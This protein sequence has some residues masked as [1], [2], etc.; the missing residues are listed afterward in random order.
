MW[1][2][3]G[4]CCVVCGVAWSAQLAGAF[5]TYECKMIFL[6]FSFTK[7]GMPAFSHL[8]LTVNRDTLLLTAKNQRTLSG[9]LETCASKKDHATNHAASS[10][11]FLVF[12]GLSKSH[13]K[14][15]R[16]PDGE[17]SK[18]DHMRPVFIFVYSNGQKRPASSFSSSFLHFVF[19]DY[20][21]RLPCMHARMR[22]VPSCSSSSLLGVIPG[23]LCFALATT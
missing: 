22:L 18:K 19:K 6:L 9:R 17:P 16:F 8:F 10:F 11:L 14:G 5:S 23:G 20:L 21:T 1:L 2:C 12:L 3:V 7:L 15:G 4:C 13:T